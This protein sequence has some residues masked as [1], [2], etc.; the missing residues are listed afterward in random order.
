MKV[1]I[2]EKPKVGRALAEFLGITSK[3][4]GFC[5]VKG[6]DIVTW[7]VGHLI[8]NA[9]PDAYLTESQRGYGNT[10]ALPIIPSEWKSEA[11][12]ETRKQLNTVISLLKKADEIWN[13][14][15][16]DREGQLVSD[17]VIE[18]AGFDPAGGRK[19]VRR[20]MLVSL[21]DKDIAKAMAEHRS[22]GELE[23]IQ[24]R[25]AALSRQRADWMVG[26]NGSRAYA[27]VASGAKI[28]VGRVQTPTLAMVVERDNEIENFRPKDYFVVTVTLPDGR[29][30]AWHGR[31]ADHPGIDDDGRI[32]SKALAEEIA[33]RIN[34]GMAGVVDKAVRLDLSQGPPNPFNLSKLQ[35]AV[36][37]RFGMSVA[38]VTKICQS[39]YENKLISYIGTDSEFLPESMHGEAKGVISGIA[40]MYGKD[41]SGANPDIKY[42]CW[43]DAKVSAHHAI[44]PTGVLPS[45]LSDAEKKVF[46]TVAKQYIAQFYP[47][48]EYAS[49]VLEVD[50]GG[51]KFVA[52]WQEPLKM[53]WKAV[54]GGGEEYNGVERE[55]DDENQQEMDR[56]V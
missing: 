25:H 20:V 32:I 55:S 52:K 37:S 51:D 27:A 35:T 12:Q 17:E 46:D 38:D 47:K 34:D 16:I 1:Y 11:K 28:S 42:P 10:A 50:F 3:G 41:A 45:G 30:L 33:R 54:L 48:Y 39:L 15:D 43:N 40:P 24:R 44:I 49:N 19:P 22:N 6:G 36:A 7:L 9:E 13:C 26:I 21:N 2:T 4:D 31:E 14:G 56:T 18:Y 23:F 8:E 29:E 5:E 53:G